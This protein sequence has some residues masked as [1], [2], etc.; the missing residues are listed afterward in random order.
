M[1]S[2]FGMSKYVPVNLAQTLFDES[3]DALFLVGADGEKVL[4]ANRAALRACR[5]ERSDIPGL[6]LHTLFRSE[7]EGGVEQLRRRCCAQGECVTEER[8]L[9]RQNKEGPWIPVRVS[10]AAREGPQAVALIRARVEAAEREQTEKLLAIQRGIV[11]KIATGA[12]LADVLDYLARAIEDAAPEMLVSILLLEDERLWHGA[13]PHLADAYNQAINGVAI[14]PEVGS[15]GTAAFFGKAVVVE[16]IATHFLWKNY[17]DLA[18]G[19]GLRACWSTPILAQTGIVLGTFAVYT[20]QVR[21]P[22]VYEQRVVDAATHLA[23]I[24]IERSRSE[25]AIRESEERYR[26]LFAGNPHPMFVYDVATLAYLDVNEAAVLHYG[27]SRAEFLKMTIKDIRPP[28]D[29]PALMASV[30]DQGLVPFR[31]GVWRHRK[32]DGAII[33]ADIVARPLTYEGRQARLVVA[34]DVTDRLQAEDALRA[35]EAKYRS[36]VDSLEQC[37]ILKDSGF[38]FVA[39]NQAFCRGLGVNEEEILGKTDYDLYPANLA[40]KYRADDQ[41][42]LAEG[43]RIELE[44]QSLLNGE[45]CTV[46]VVKTP[47]RDGQ[48][49]PA[50][51]L[52]IFWDV[53]RQRELEA[54]LGQAQKM[55][56]VGHLAGGIAH[57]FNNL[58]T[59][60]LGNLSLLLDDLPSDHPDRDLAISAEKAGLRAADLTRQLL[61]FSRRTMLQPRPTNLN[62]TVDEVVTIL[63]RTIDPRIA[64]E[65]RTDSNLWT[66]LADPGQMSQVLM[67]LC[68]NARD[69]MPNGGRLSLMTSN[70]VLSEEYASHHL[71]ASAGPYVRV[72]V[73]DTG[74]GMAAEVQT[75]IFEPF[76]TTKGP[77][78]GT[79][80]GLSMVFGIIQQHHG[81]VECESEHGQ[82]TC[83]ALYLPRHGDAECV[84]GEPQ[85]ASIAPRG[86]ETILLVDDEEMIR[87]L[88]RTILERHGYEVLAAEDGRQAVEIYKRER[89]RIDLVILDLT[90][91][92]LSG[93]DAFAQLTALNPDVRALFASGY[94]AENVSAVENGSILGFVGKPYSPQELAQKVRSALDKPLRRPVAGSSRV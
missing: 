86:K 76:F 74:C 70:V 29:V 79:G 82:G 71:E 69:A 43:R 23:A 18:L 45:L 52:G 38:R 25:Q 13:A 41:R 68:L 51:V 30:R 77:G 54:Q 55:E 12:G 6:T 4:D 40:D 80:L 93:Q 61:G 17:R 94:S 60:I 75:R 47:A 8:F 72:E 36:L 85:T 67:N 66:V 1:N 39:A 10:V 34:H 46:R 22:T 58:L 24:A 16:D 92:R 7:S 81:W 50:G 33:H 32:R 15:C 59:A 53:T 26:F 35:S 19:Q 65:V 64:V 56:A 90:M 49:R 57:D 31:A 11:D 62:A 83:F 73:S 87:D 21:G 88:G 2:N 3:S 42:V 89:A 44:E 37:I 28:E 27:Y 5:L 20:R 48:G 9:L 14:G 84:R 91:P 78:K 63:R